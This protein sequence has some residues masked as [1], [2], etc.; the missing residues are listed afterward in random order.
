MDLCIV[1]GNFLEN[2]IEA[3]RIMKHGEKFIRVRAQIKNDALSVAVENSF[4][5]EWRERGGVYMSRKNPGGEG[6]PRE[7]VGLTSVRAVCA[8]YDGKMKVGIKGNVWRSSALLDLTGHLEGT[9]D[10][11]GDGG[12][13]LTKGS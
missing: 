3:C 5:G 2:A 12:A 4:D 11:G 9:A 1:V 13:D 6:V 8:K 10:K 7:G